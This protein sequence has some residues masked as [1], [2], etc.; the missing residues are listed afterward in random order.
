MSGVYTDV[1]APWSSMLE[2]L[3]CVLFLSKLYIGLV[4]GL[5]VLVAKQAAVTGLHPW[6]F[7]IYCTYTIIAPKLL[8]ADYFCVRITV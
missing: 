5:A 4:K 1:S 2:H 3:G 6:T 7:K 8:I